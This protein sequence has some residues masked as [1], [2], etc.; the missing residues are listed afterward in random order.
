M[1]VAEHRTVAFCPSK[2]KE[3][4]DPGTFSQN[5]S[6]V[7][8]K[9]GLREGQDGRVGGCG[10]HPSSQTHQKYISMWNIA[11]RKPVGNWQ[12]IYMTKAAR[13]IST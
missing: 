7:L 11:H 13:Q 4:R 12:K 2:Q 9:E 10:A 8:V 3:L 6:N 5:P 1:E